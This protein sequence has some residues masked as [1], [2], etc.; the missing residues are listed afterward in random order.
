[1][2]IYLSLIFFLI[3]PSYQLVSNEIILASSASYL[4]SNKE[5][6]I[7]YLLGANTYFDYVNK[8]GGIKGRKIKLLSL[9]DSYV[10]ELTVVNTIKFLENRDL[11]MLFNYVGTPTTNSILPMLK[12]EEKNN[13]ILFGNLTGSGSQRDAPYNSF[14]YNIRS[15]YGDETSKLVDYFLA[16]GKKRI[17]VFYQIDDFGQSGFSGIKKSLEEKG[18]VIA[19]ETSYK[20][21]ATWND[22]ME[23]QA[24]YLKEKEVDVIISISTYEAAAGFIRDTRAIGLNVPISNISFVDVN[25]LF[26]ILRSNSVDFNELYFTEILPSFNNDTYPFIKKYTQIF[27]KSHYKMNFISLE[28]FLNAYI[29][30]EILRNTDYEINRS[31]IKDIIE[32]M[33]PIDLGFGKHVAFTKQNHNL[34][35]S[36]YI[37][38]GL[39][40]GGIVEVQ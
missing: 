39:K 25:A 29:L 1:M 3:I 9:N 27:T 34:L 2:R 23:A 14:V 37:Y 18:L 38:K 21:G 12:L 24:R 6:G 5:L 30:V 13:L 26:N 15:S 33:S 22:S 32:N 4:G 31:N 10:P 35:N 7:N 40:G 17:G 11:L 36:V 8:N 19:G 20:K 28:G 16:Q